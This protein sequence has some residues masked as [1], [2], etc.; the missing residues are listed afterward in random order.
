MRIKLKKILLG[1]FI[2]APLTAIVTTATLYS[3]K[4]PSGAKFARVDET[5]FEI[6]G[7]DNTPITSLPTNT[8]LEELEIETYDE[9]YWGEVAEYVDGENQIKLYSLNVSHTQVLDSTNQFSLHDSYGQ[10]YTRTQTFRSVIFYQVST[11]GSWEFTAYKLA[12]TVSTT[13][14]YYNRVNAGGN[15]FRAVTHFQRSSDGLGFYVADERVSQ[16]NYSYKIRKDRSLFDWFR[17]ESVHT[18]AAY[19]ERDDI[20]VT[21]Y[22]TY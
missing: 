15:I 1:A 19:Y 4:T 8:V 2:V 6:I 18:F 12:G 9:A 14:T 16:T 13:L 7:G 21:M 3:I 10:T 5:T 17:Y 11:V 22:R 20:A